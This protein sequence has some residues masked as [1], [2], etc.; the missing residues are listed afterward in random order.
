MQPS[1]AM[2]GVTKR[3]RTRPLQRHMDDLPV[4]HS[5]SEVSYAHNVYCI[6]YRYGMPQIFVL[7]ASLTLSPAFFLI[8]VICCL[9]QLVLLLY[10]HGHLQACWRMHW[11]C[12]TWACCLCTGC[13]VRYM[14][15]VMHGTCGRCS[16]SCRPSW[17]SQTD[18]QAHTCCYMDRQ[19]NSNIKQRLYH[20]LGV[21]LC[22]RCNCGSW[23]LLGLANK[24]Q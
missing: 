1:V 22:L 15:R 3:S 11:P 17:A 2:L 7:P 10:S 24:Q 6:L 12:H 14:Q 4:Y 5:N 18:R 20:T 8:V 13:G 23:V 16:T 21:H 9:L 19:A